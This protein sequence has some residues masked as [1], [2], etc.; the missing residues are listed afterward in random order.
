MPATL[1]SCHM[2]TEIIANVILTHNFERQAITSYGKKM[3]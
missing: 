2:K 1:P 3:P